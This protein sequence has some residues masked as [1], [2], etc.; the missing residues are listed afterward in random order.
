MGAGGKRP[1]GKGEALGGVGGAGGGSAKNEPF[2]LEFRGRT[3]HLTSAG[4]VQTGAAED[5]RVYLS[6][7]DFVSWTGVQP[8]TVEVA[9]SG[10]RDEILT[11]MRPLQQMIPN[12]DVQPVRQIVDGEAR[13][14]GKTRATL[15]AAAAL[16][17]CP[18]PLCVD[19]KST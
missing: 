11:V 18:S 19:R 14:L 12:A 6:L 13:V 1:A 8:S 17:I 16:I 3:I 15:L 4:T 10:G 9:T 7:Q 2:Y 5:S